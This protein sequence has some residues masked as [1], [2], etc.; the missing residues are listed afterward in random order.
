MGSTERSST[1]D[2]KKADLVIVRTIEDL[3]KA[4]ALWRQA[5]ETVGM[6]PTMGA[7]HPGH[8]SLV[9]QMNGKTD[10]SVAT[11]FVNPTQFAP[12][13]DFD[14]Y[15]RT[16]DTDVQKLTRHGVDLVFIPNAREMYP[17][18]FATSMTVGGPALGLETDY[19]PHFFSGVAIVVAK[20]LL[21]CSPDMAIFGEKDYQ[22]LLVIRQM[23]RDLNLPT[24]IIGGETVREPDGLALSS[25][26]AY[27][28][29]EERRKATRLILTLR[30]TA[31]A[32]KAGR[33]TQTALD[34]AIARLT[35]VGF[36]VDYVALRN[37]ETLAEIRDRTEEPGRL[38]A[39]AWM[40]KTRLIDNIPV[41]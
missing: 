18:G 24:Q 1:C 23:A 11:I 31:I 25:R 32:L 21:T 41:L 29:D 9:D 5:G 7:L 3:R 19:R 34:E 13:E 14:S 39:A 37:A 2:V 4:V 28:S 30:E 22:Q 8:L 38:L 10:R 17:E 15:P 26:N 27:L 12:H 6:I 16:E 20:L 36:K 33:D 35:E 40:G